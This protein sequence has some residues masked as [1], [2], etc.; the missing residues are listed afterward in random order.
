MT[1]DEWKARSRDFERSASVLLVN[2]Q[3]SVAYH[4]A[5]LAIECALKAKIATL[6]RKNDVPEKQLVDDFY[7]SGHVLT[8]LIRLAGLQAAL[9]VEEEASIGFRA[10]WATVQEWNINSRYLAWTELEATNMINATARRGTGVPPWI[11]RHW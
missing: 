6:F 5:G 7:R 2:G 10:S 11:R 3:H 4:I 8:A 9:A 1:R